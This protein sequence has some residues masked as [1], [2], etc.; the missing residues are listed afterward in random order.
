MLRKV[1]FL[2]IPL[3]VLIA[4]GEV[5]GQGNQIM[6]PSLE[7]GIRHDFYFLGNSGIGDPRQLD[8]V[9]GGLYNKAEQCPGTVVFLGNSVPFKSKLKNRSAKVNIPTANILKQA[10]GL[11]QKDFNVHYLP[12]VSEWSFGLKGLR[13]LQHELEQELS[14]KDIFLPRNGCPIE[15]R[16]VNK[17]VHL[18]LIDSYWAMMNWDAMPGINAGCD[19][20]SRED[21]YIEIEDEIVKSQGK[22]L[23]VGMHHP[24]VSLG[25]LGN[26][27]GFGLSPN[28]LN[29]PDYRYFRER[30]GTMAKQWPNVIFVAA[31]EQSLQLQFM[32]QTPML[33]SGSASGATK[34]RR[35]NSEKDFALASSGF[36]RV[37]VNGNGSVW[38]EFFAK[39][40]GFAK[41]IYRQEIQ[42]A[43]EQPAMT[44]EIYSDSL[45]KASI[46]ANKPLANN[47]FNRTLFGTNYM[48]DYITTVGV[49]AVNLDTLRGGL[50]V[51]RK[52]GGHQTQSLRLKDEQGRQYTLRSLEK[53]ALR[54]V[55]Y[56]IYKTHYL[57]PEYQETYLLRMLQEYWTTANPYGVLTI[58]ELSDAL[59][60]LH[61][62]PSLYF[63]PSQPALGEF[64][65]DFGNRLY[66]FEEH[67]S[68][69]HGDVGK[70]GYSDEIISSFKLLKKLKSRNRVTIDKS[71]YIRNRLFDNLI[72]DWDRH[73]DQWRWA[74]FRKADGLEYYRPIPRDRDQAYSNFDGTFLR[75]LTFLAPPLRFMQSY[76]SDFKHI[77]W[78]NDAGDDLDLAVLDA[79]N[80]E[81]WLREAKYIKRHLTDTVISRAFDQLPKEVD[82]I[83]A[84]KVKLALK[85]RLEKVESLA[86][87][88]YNNLSR[89]IL[90]AG[91]EG[92]DTF[93][94]VR[95]PDGS[96]YIEGNITGEKG[97]EPFWQQ[98]YDPKVTREIWIYGLEGED[99]FEI[100]GPGKGNIFLRIIGGHGQDYYKAINKRGV[101][102]YDYHSEPNSI[103]GSIR[104][105]LSDRYDLNTYHYK[106]HPRKI[107]FTSPI[108]AYERD[109]KLTLGFQYIA[110][111]RSMYR[112]PFTSQHKFS[113]RYF[114]G[115]SGAAFDYSGEFTEVLPK[116]NFGIDARYSSPNHVLNFFGL[117]NQSINPEGQFGVEYNQVRIRRVHLEPKL[118]RRGYK[119]S[120]LSFSAI[121]DY[122]KVE[123]SV[124]RYIS[125]GTISEELFGGNHFLGAAANYYY[126]NFDS[127]LQPRLGLG[128]GITAG[129]I[130]NPDTKLGYSYLVPELRITNKL[131]LNGRWILATKVKGQLIGNDHFA[132]YQ[133]ASLGGFE[134][135]RGFRQQRF[136][137]KRAIY[138]TTDLRIAVGQLNKGV[139]PTGIT[140]YGGFDYGR[141]WHP[142][143]RSG[144]WHTSTGGGVY[145]NL[146]GFLTGNIAYF[147][148]SE[149]GQ[150]VVG[151]SVP[152]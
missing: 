24:L 23:I 131:A 130:V 4:V 51:I 113:A 98:T 26:P 147:N 122:Y 67:L 49:R 144:L 72:G 87:E 149:G 28:S 20:Q 30:V 85:A 52:G 32:D 15:K 34:V 27:R 70:L 105:K 42:P 33:V 97:R 104:R 7:A 95:N 117:G 127:A 140:L 74:R 65:E 83:R 112:E 9:M 53:S 36:I 73:A 38:A 37:S 50:K 145:I 3:F 18:L 91:T 102:I 121:Y 100:S 45:V 77:K 93:T 106:K 115:T 109:N 119:N 120:K 63:V 39:D 90:V 150:L 68:D 22:T 5:L 92:A 107:G 58:G 56:F 78:F 54:F 35:S 75:T 82:Q 94:I 143:E 139:L 118:I 47:A 44:S 148:S 135:L 110:T 41:P 81:D 152:F 80:L 46:Y 19:I 31:H 66:Y 1:K 103:Q 69:G 21:F 111:H 151:L 76:G 141:V 123:R 64:N 57:S 84:E 142:G 55:Q 101:R 128:Y 134:G 114:S 136:A 8:E 14:K 137:G 126:E 12:G 71:L 88:L 62:S 89:N 2:L 133:A 59:A 108:L 60:I 146:M 43:I 116:V 79:H 86:V 99:R 132:F 6:D 10:K 138:Q 25:P 16:K 13:H 17:K 125:S 40:N 96:V 29:D 124:R 61:P 129:F 48:Q 11:F